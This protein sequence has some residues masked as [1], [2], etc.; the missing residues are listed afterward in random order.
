MLFAISAVTADPWIPP[1][2]A[3]HLPIPVCRFAFQPSHPK[4]GYGMLLLQK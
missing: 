3:I 2:V 4:E 1:L